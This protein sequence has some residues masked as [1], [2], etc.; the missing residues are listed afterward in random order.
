MTTQNGNDAG[1]AGPLDRLPSRRAM[2]KATL[3]GAAG[4]AGSTF[5]PCLA[6]TDEQDKRVKRTGSEVTISWK[7]PL[8]DPQAKPGETP[9]SILTGPFV[10]WLTESQ[11]NIGCE[12]IAK[13][14]ITN[15]FKQV[16][17]LPGETD[18][19]KDLQFR[20]FTISGL[21]P[22]TTYR[23]RLTSSDGAY[24]FASKV[25]QFRTLPAATATKVRFAV[26]G[27]THGTTGP[28]QPWADVTARLFKDIQQW[29]PALVLHVGDIV[30]DSWGQRIDGRRGWPRVFDLCREL[31]A[32]AFMAPALGNHDI[33]VGQRIWAPEYFANLPAQKSNRAGPANPPFYYS[34]DV[35]NI[36]F[37]AL[38]TEVR[39]RGPKGEDLSG[40][41]VYDK[42]TYREQLAWLEEDLR[43]SR[44]PWKIAF[45]H[46]PLHTV[47]RYP[48][49]PEFFHDFGGLFDRYKV[50]VLLSGHD[51]SYQRTRR[52]N[53]ATRRLS[54]DGTVQVISG[55]AAY[56]FKPVHKADW[57]VLH[58]QVYHYLRM[59]VSDETLRVDAVLDT[60]EIFESWEMKTMGQPTVLKNAPV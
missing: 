59:E 2:L 48:C 3:S 24:R 23:Y 1:A 44:A 19:R 37:V 58:A 54:D 60:G 22:D 35:A 26:I 7:E 28:N 21:K 39:Q 40:A 25:H 9:F 17:A 8:K 6:W 31:R 4:L 41:R 57:N 12:V 50:A 36:H 14:G 43:G 51:H 32:S 27:D 18:M 11:A 10:G 5:V 29:E 53:N 34:F 49:R 16:L 45:F 55:G 13:K 33:Q 52:I 46:Q 56:L 38:C 20:A 42:F 30:H 47:G 15:A